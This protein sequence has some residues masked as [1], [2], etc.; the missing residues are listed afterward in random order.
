[1][2]AYRSGQGLREQAAGALGRRPVLVGGTLAVG[3]VGGVL[4]EHKPSTAILLCVCAAAIV[5]FA[6]LGDRAFPWAIVIVAVAPWYP[7]IAETA[8]SPLVKQEVLCAAIAAAPL[9]PWLWSLALGGRRTRPSQG[10]LL[11]G[12]LFLG[13]AIL[14]YENLDSLTKVISTGIVGYVF[15]GVT[16][17]CARRFGNA[18]GWPAAAFTGVLVLVLLG[19]DA[20][21]RD[22][23]NRIGYFSGYP[24]TYGGLVAGLLPCALLFASERSRLL[25]AVTAASASAVLIFSQS[26]SSW[27]AVTV[28]LIVV[29][30]VQA[31]A[32]NYR[33]LRGIAMVVVVL[34]AL[35]LSTSS[36]HRIVGEKLSSK[37]DT[38]QSVTHREWSYH[39][40][41]QKIGSSPV[42]GAEE[43]GFSAKESFSKTTIGAIDDGYVSIAVDMGLVGLI[44]ALIPVGIALRVLGRCMRFRVTPRYELALALGIV[45]MA[46]VAAFYDSFYWAQLDLLLGAMGGVLSTRIA[47]I[48]RPAAAAKGQPRQGARELQTGDLTSR[49]REGALGWAGSWG[50]S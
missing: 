9:A 3:L 19:A 2:S 40:A 8:E 30:I 28:M 11:M 31:R 42:F 39:Y 17:L 34:T 4:A 36:L 33:A 25:T 24:I 10:S 29:A 15:I 48:T 43:P 37:I 22:P 32:G 35:I 12:F 27:V 16:F 13:L 1:V 45:G 18:R 14:I 50:S 23:G 26:R 47:G 46:V 38:S 21:I 7:F 6:M 49:R 5:G 44:A 20:Y 41:L